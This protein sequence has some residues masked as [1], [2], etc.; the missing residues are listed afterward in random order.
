MSSSVLHMRVMDI[1]LSDNTKNALREAGVA[2]LYLFGSRAQEKN[3]PLSDYDF[4]IL[5]TNPTRLKNGTMDS[6]HV[7]YPILAD[8][9]R[10]ETL[11]ADVIDIVFLDSSHVPLELK[12]NIVRTGKVLFNENEFLR[13]DFTSR[14]L[15][16]SADF[17]PL[18][19]EMSAALVTRPAVL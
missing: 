15:L 17:A 10:P 18:R 8:L 2:V 12:S 9:T 16:Q 14:I 13:S 19:K 5:L 11:D 3:S 7:L 4:G 1:C 6:Y